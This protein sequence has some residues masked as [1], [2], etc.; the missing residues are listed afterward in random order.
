D[1]HYLLREKSV[2]DLA[3]SVL[4]TLGR[5]D[6]AVVVD[7]DANLLAFG[8]IV[9]HPLGADAL[10]VTE[11]GRSTAAVT[12]SHAGKVLKISEDGLVRFSDGGGCVWDLCGPR[13][14]VARGQRAPASPRGW[15]SRARR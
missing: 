6:G 5:I 2:L 8:A 13:P 9:R 14:W 11:G 3:P 12:A 4:E 7:S 1:L 10:E 15:R